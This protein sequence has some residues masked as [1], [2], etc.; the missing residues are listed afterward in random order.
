MS[1]QRPLRLRNIRRSTALCLAG[2]G[3]LLAVCAVL[4]AVQRQKT[5]L[6][7]VVA[8]DGEQVARLPLAVN[9]EYTVTTERGRNI[10]EVRDG[11]VCVREADCPDAT[12]VRQGSVRH[13][14]ECIVCLPHRLVVTV[15]GREGEG[16]L[17]VVARA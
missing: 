17:G 7:A 1:L 13:V 16:V 8:V 12:C 6:Y 14:G 4:L 2:L 10:V 15:E 3:L 5:G 11:A 9:R